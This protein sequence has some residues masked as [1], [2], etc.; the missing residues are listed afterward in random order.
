MFPGKVYRYFK[1][2]PTPT[3]LIETTGS[4]KRGHISVAWSE[5]LFPRVLSTNGKIKVYILQFLRNLYDF[6]TLVPSH[7]E[8]RVLERRVLPRVFLPKSKE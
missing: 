1:G 7:R 4:S 5:I 8:L 3:L 2:F 6:E